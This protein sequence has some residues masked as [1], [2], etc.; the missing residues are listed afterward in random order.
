MHGAL[1]AAAGG[2]L[3]VVIAMAIVNGFVAVSPSGIPRLDAIHVDLPVLGFAAIVSIAT[4][5]AVG[6][7]PAWQSTDV[8]TVLKHGTPSAMGDSHGR[9]LRRALIVAEVAISVVLLVGASLLGRSLVRLLQTDIGVTNGAVTAALVDLSFGRRLSMTE[10]RLLIDRIVERVGALPGVVSAG[11]GASMPPN[12]ARLRF[13]TGQTPAAPGE[14]PPNYSIDVVTATPGYFSALGLRLQNGRLFND[15][16]DGSHPHVMILTRSTARQLLGDVDPIGRTISLP[17][18]TPNGTT[19]GSVAVVGVVDDVKY[20]G[21]ETPANAVIY[22]PF[23]QQPWP[24]MFI[25]ARTAREI[26]NFAPTLGREIAAVDPDVGI[27]FVNTLASMISDATAQPRFRAVVFIAIAA[28]ALTLAAVGLYGVVAYAVAQRTGEIGIRMALGAA[29][30]DVVRLVLREGMWLAAIGLALGIGA[31][32]M[33]AQFVGSLLFGI[34]PTDAVSFVA[35]AAL[36]LAIAM[37]ASYLP[38]RRASRVDPLI[39]LRS[40]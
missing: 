39:A 24:S 17:I 22:R 1:I 38:A 34:Q 20:S 12:L 4:T 8:M 6:I 40:E 9:R 15:A 25:V 36:L 16:D 26:E 31:A 3:G 37:L 21:L 32:R 27:Q 23:A 14:L 19:N 35:A 30:G 11:A 13:T 10:Q 18:L 5:L 2:G 7:L 29:S 28:L 33:L